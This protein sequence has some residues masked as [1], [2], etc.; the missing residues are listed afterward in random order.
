MSTAVRMSSEE[1]RQ[2]R[3]KLLD[4]VNMTYEQLHELAREY[5]LRSEE[6]AAYETIR[7]IDYLLGE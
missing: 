2:L 3:Q 1:L 6:R 4:E 5:A 7:G